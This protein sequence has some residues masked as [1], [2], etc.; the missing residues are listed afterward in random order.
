MEPDKTSAGNSLNVR[1]QV[2]P[3]L[4]ETFQL[5]DEQALFRIKRIPRGYL[6]RSPV[7]RCVSARKFNGTALVAVGSPACWNGRTQRYP[8]RGHLI[9]SRRVKFDRCSSGHLDAPR[10]I[11]FSSTPAP[12]RGGSGRCIG[13]SWFLQLALF[14]NIDECTPVGLLTS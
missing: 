14:V 7:K 13:H 12:R 6:A 5:D 3:R 8:P 2:T 1:G 9:S 4:N 11:E 10:K